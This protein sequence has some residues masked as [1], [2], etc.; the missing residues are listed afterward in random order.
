MI[1][2]ISH[3]RTK[4]TLV[5]SS[6]FLVDKMLSKIDF[7]SPLKIAQLGFGTGVF[8]RQLLQSMNEGSRLTV[9]EV[10]RDCTKHFIKNPKV[11]YVTDSATNL[12]DYH[13]SKSLD[14]IV[15]TLPLASLP[16]PIALA[17][18]EVSSQALKKNGLFLQYQYSLF[19]RK[20]IQD[21]FQQEAQISFELRNVPPAFVYQVKKNI[22]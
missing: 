12:L 7:G 1:K 14:C 8:T 13:G 22:N 20:M 10:D 6:R 19:S 3:W 4:G 17:A 16:K 9:F 11:D 18:C 21:V 2:T 15:S 5:P